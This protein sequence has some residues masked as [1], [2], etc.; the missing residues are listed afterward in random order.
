MH[1]LDQQLVTGVLISMSVV[2]DLR[3]CEGFLPAHTN[4]LQSRSLLLFEI[5]PC[6]F[7]QYLDHLT[8]HVV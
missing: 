6:T 5:S 1:L 2:S 4:S 7:L 3:R 8:E